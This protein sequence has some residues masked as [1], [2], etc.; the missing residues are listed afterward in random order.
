MTSL[1]W[2]AVSKVQK[3]WALTVSHLRPTS[4][5]GDG[6][7]NATEFSDWLLWTTTRALRTIIISSHRVLGVFSLKIT[8][9]NRTMTVSTSANKGQIGQQRHEGRIFYQSTQLNHAVY[10]L[11]AF[12]KRNKWEVFCRQTKIFLGLSLN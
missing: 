7:Q 9:F 5:I 8:H 2:A 6:S 11:Q 10:A 1:K 12:K 4:K 3:K